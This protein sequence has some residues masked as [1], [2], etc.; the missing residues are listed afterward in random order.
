MLSAIEEWT[1]I[2]GFRFFPVDGAHS[3]TVSSLYPPEGISAVEL[4]KVIKSEGITPGSGYGKVK[5]TNIRIGH[6]GDVDV[7]SVKNL[8]AAY[9]R[10]VEKLRAKVP[11]GAG[12]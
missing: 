4:N 11:A 8:L 2:S 10:C 1:K 5:E 6:M 9:D 3:P 12:A 7:L